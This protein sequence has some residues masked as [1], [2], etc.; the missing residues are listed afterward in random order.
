M[1]G[2]SP[3]A[4]TDCINE[5][6]DLVSS[7]LNYVLEHGIKTVSLDVFDT[8]VFRKVACPAE[9]FSHAFGFVPQQ[10]NINMCAAEFQELRVHAEKQAKR[11]TLSGEVSL[12][13]IYAKLPFSAEVTA[14][15]L[16]AELSAEKSLSFVYPPMTQLIIELQTLGIEVLLISDMY[17]S[18][19]QIRQCFFATCPVLQNLPLFVSS[20]HQLNKSAGL[21]FN[22]VAEQKQLDKSTWLHLGDNPLSDFNMPKQQ[23]IQ[24][25][26][27]SPQ[28]DD[29]AIFHLESTLFPTKQ[30]FNAARSLASVHYA[31]TSEPVAFNIG[32]L[33]WGP[34]LFSF[35]DWV[36]NQTIQAKSKCI[37]CLMR[38][39]EVFAPLLELRLQQ[40]NIFEISVKKLYASRKSTFWPAIEIQTPTWFDDLIYILVQRRGYTVDDFYR[41]FQLSGDDIH[42]VHHEVLIRDADSLF[43]QGNNLLK[44]LTSQARDNKQQVKAYIEQQ[45]ALFV[46]YYEHHIGED[47]ETSAVLDLGNGGTIQHHIESIFNSKSRVNLLLYSTDRIYRY[48]HSTVYTS[49]V[50]ANNDVI[51][52]RQILFRSPECIEPFLVGDAGTT[53]GYRDDHRGSPVLAERLK[54]NSAPVLAFMQGVVGYFI[55]HHTLGFSQ[56]GAEQVVP[57]LYR[58]VQLPTELEA[59]LFKLLLHQDNFGSN[60]AYPIITKSQIDQIEQISLTRFYQDFCQ[61]PKM[62]LGQIHWPQAVLTL[63]SPSFLTRQLGFTSADSDRDVLILVERLIQAKWTRFSVYGAGL[64][65]EKLQ[66]YL[67]KNNL[68]I[69]HLIDRKA[70][71][72]GQ[73]IVAGYDVISLNSAL[74][75]GCQKILISSF[76]FKDEIARNIYEQSLKREHC[77]V[78]VLSL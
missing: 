31:D 75:K 6:Q 61:H 9:V 51:G 1:T 35:I 18:A 24:A 25:W 41:D 55:T 7:I 37:L 78:E 62:K 49:F 69:E 57:I 58:Y 14:R 56:I 13:D 70:E 36:I 71:I 77:K 26:C 38:E 20:E 54:A 60:D 72:S 5:Q 43:Y 19:T 15:L 63:I 3:S 34:I 44:L 52:L 21:M 16:Q 29:S 33:V 28:L 67:L 39:A 46:R 30:H 53:L 8:I 4:I 73:Y 76:A 17:L 64:F 68:K 2:A 65:F 48:S 27:L 12:E 74:E 42:K 66:P 10:F 22:H 59:E 47:F 11:N 32:S 23:G 40:R 50:N 45:K